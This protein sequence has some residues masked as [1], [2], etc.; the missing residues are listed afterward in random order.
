MRVSLPH[1]SFYFTHGEIAVNNEDNKS[2]ESPD[3]NPTGEL[4]LINADIATQASSTTNLRAI[5]K[6][7]EQEIEWCSFPVVTR[8]DR[9]KVAMARQSV[10]NDIDAMKSGSGILVSHI[11]LTYQ[12]YTNDK[13]EVVQGPV[14]NLYAPDGTLY[15]ISAYYLVMQILNFAANWDE[16]PWTPPVR[17]RCKDVITPKGN[18]TY[19]LVVEE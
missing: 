15:R 17:M 1:L 10:A 8:G 6:N 16:F 14:A 12:C 11:L 13:G 7:I 3:H 18:R 5:L 2:V 4:A 19:N 9:M